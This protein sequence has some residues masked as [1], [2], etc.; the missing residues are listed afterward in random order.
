VRNEYPELQPLNLVNQILN[1]IGTFYQEASKHIHSRIYST[2]LEQETLLAENTVHD[3]KMVFQDFSQTSTQ[4]FGHYFVL[5]IKQKPIASS[6]GYAEGQ[7]DEIK[8]ILKGNQTGV[9]GII[10]KV[11]EP[12]IFHLKLDILP[13]QLYLY[14]LRGHNEQLTALEKTM[15][16]F[17]DEKPK[18]KKAVSNAKQKVEAATKRR[19]EIDD[20][21]TTGGRNLDPEVL[22]KDRENQVQIIDENNAIIKQNQAKLDEGKTAEKKRENIIKGKF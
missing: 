4:K 16:K 6:K 20:M 11:P 10:V 14:R 13:R 12:K 17:E 15:A 2:N 22:K 21:I 7:P 9:P 1:D 3:K 19:D 8:S 18:F 5:T